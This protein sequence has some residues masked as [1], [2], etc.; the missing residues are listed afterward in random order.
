MTTINLRNFYPWYIQD[1]IIE[2]TDEVA[3]ALRSDKLY[4]AAHQRRIVR[5]KAQYSL[6][7]DDGVEYSACLHEPTPQ[8][9]LERME[10]F[11]HLWN[12]LNTL[13]EVQGRR[14]DTCVILGK[15]YREVAKVEGVDKSAI[16]RSVQCGLE[17]MKKYLKRNF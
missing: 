2:V 6:D 7:C 13:P 5:N 9:L 10:R 1:E 12:A 14:V 4:E 17:A 8:E 15:S 3:K 16:R 11:C